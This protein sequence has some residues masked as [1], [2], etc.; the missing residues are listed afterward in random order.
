MNETAVS[1]QGIQHM[2]LNKITYLPSDK[3]TTGIII[4]IIQKKLIIIKIK[5]FK[6]MDGK[7]QHLLAKI[8][9]LEIFFSAVVN[10][11]CFNDFM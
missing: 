5:M 6:K 1:T 3:I 10:F 2:E 8:N 7:L 11:S 4:V 9:L